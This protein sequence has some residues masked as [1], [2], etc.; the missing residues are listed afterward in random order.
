ME[1]GCGGLLYYE[2]LANNL[3]PWWGVDEV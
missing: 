1:V 3:R 2:E